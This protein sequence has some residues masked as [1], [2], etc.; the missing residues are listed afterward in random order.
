L[1]EIIKEGSFSDVYKPSTRYWV[2]KL[3]A[4]LGEEAFLCAI[5]NALK[6]PSSQTQLKIDDAITHIRETQK[7]M[8][9]LLAGKRH[10]NE[11]LCRVMGNENLALMI[12][13]M[14]R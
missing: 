14:T 10:E 5:Q 9:L 8:E 11:A 1:I 12:H 2:R 6:Y 13:E 3:A 7:K 4:K